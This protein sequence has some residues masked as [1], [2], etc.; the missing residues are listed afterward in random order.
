MMLPG[1]SFD[2]E[3]FAS[4]VAAELC[5]VKMSRWH[6]FRYWLGDLLERWSWKLRDGI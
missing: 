2:G 5:P 6:S 4:R 3:E 1:R